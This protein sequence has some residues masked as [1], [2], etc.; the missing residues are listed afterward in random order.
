MK[1][2]KFPTVLFY[3]VIL[4]KAHYALTCELWLPEIFIITLLLKR[5][6][7]MQ[8]ILW[9]KWKSHKFAPWYV[10]YEACVEFMRHVNTTL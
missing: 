3:D 2:L 9:M 4:D 8:V 10:Y 1:T 5:V 6:S 7:A